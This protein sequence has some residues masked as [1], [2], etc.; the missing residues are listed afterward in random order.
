MAQGGRLA[1][2]VVIVTGG[3]QGIGRALCQ[4]FAEEGA[5]VVVADV[6]ART[7]AAVA[8]EI[9]QSGG[10][11]NDM[12]VD[13]ADPS[14][15]T[16]VVQ[17]SVEL[18]GAVD[19]LVNNAAVFS[20]IRMGPFEEISMD[21]WDAVMRVNVRGAFLCCQAVAGQMRGQR[22]GSIINMSS[23]TVLMGR[24]GYAHYVTSKAAII[25]MSRALASELGV[26][27]IRVNAILPGAIETEIP[28][29]TVSEEQARGLVQARALKRRATVADIVGAAVF[30]ASDDSSFI[31]GQ[32]LVVDGGN[33][34]L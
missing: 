4:R 15:A 7:A 31:T 33:R 18:H 20:K 32:S 2:R 9:R 21:E 10:E 30:L 26:D 23:G 22:R 17:R 8:R 25:G 29:E 28:R 14:G 3:G 13:I 12:S 27:N 34:Y 6:N 24:P 16:Q 19:V 1:G 5:R 11:A